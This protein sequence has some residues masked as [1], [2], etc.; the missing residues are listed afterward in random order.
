MKTP[1]IAPPPEP[2]TPGW[3]VTQYRK[4]RGLE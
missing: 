3:Y 2:D 1:E 4:I